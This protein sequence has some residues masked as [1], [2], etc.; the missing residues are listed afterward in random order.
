MF[1]RPRRMS[2]FSAEIRSHIEMETDRLQA[3]GMDA[4]ASRA[5][6]IRE[7]GNRAASEERFFESSPASVVEGLSRDLR[8]ASRVLRKSPAFTL[9]A[10]LSLALGIGANTAIFQLVD[11]VRL[12][13]LPVK[14][15]DQLVQ[16]RLTSMNKVRGS[17]NGLNTLTYPIWNEIRG[18]QQA[19]SEIFAWSTSAYDLA[20]AGEPRF[21]Q[22]MVVSGG[23]FS[24][25]GLEPKLGRLFQEADDT[26]GCGFP[27]VVIS[28]TFWQREYGGLPGAIGSKLTLNR[29]PVEIIGVTSPGFFGMVVGRSFDVAVPVCTQGAL[30]GT[31]LQSLGTTWWMTVMG[32]VKPG[33]NVARASAYFK[34]LSPSVFQVSLPANY[35][36]V[37]VVDYVALQLVADP[38][39]RGVS[40]LREEYSEPLYLLLAIAGVVLL[41]TCANLANLMLARASAREREIAVRLAI[42]ASRGRL[43]R[44]L[45]VETLLI[46]IAGASLGLVAARVLSRLLVSLL[47]TQGNMVFINLDR[48]WRVFAFAGA[49]AVLTAI[50]F[51]LAPA[52]RSTRTGSGDV[53]KLAGRGTTAS[54]EGF[55]LRRMLVVVQVAL[56]LVLVVGALLFAGTLNNLLSAETGFRPEGVL[57]A[58]VGFGAL[59][60]PKERIAGFRQDLLE[61]LRSIP[62]VAAAGDTDTVPLSGN[63]TS[64]AVW[65]EGQLQSQAHECMRSHIGPGYF[66]ALQIPLLAGR[67]IDLHDGDASPRVAV[68]NE[69][70]ARGLMGGA[71]PVGKRLW[72]EATPSEPAASYEIVGM[73]RNTKYG[74]LREK[75]PPIVYQAQSQDPLPT[76]ADSFVIRSPLPMDALTTAVRG[77][78]TDASPGIRYQFQVFKT[79]IRDTLLQERLMASLSS[80]FGILASLLAAIGLYGVMAYL[81]TRRRNE[82]GIRMALGAGR[83]EI[84]GMVLRESGILLGSGL[85]AGAVLSQFATASVA[86][87]LFGLKATDL[88]SL[89]GAAGLLAVVALAASYVPARRAANLD[90]NTA[91]REE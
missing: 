17:R 74:E 48:D 11:A 61:R 91:L 8:Y 2:D 39:G 68:V 15:P 20:T 84:V 18:R 10:V 81:V 16:V 24:A 73:V 88:R 59:H 31:D 72:V 85:V 14:N 53:L 45:M 57:I 83:R 66:D 65:M 5:Q 19:L 13:M 42:G 29:H 6:A 25:L 32:R 35:P 89:L 33:W 21:I 30:L 58:R 43:V 22:G 38:A 76:P 86:S 34:S 28:Y 51:G 80:A 78:L 54:R 4:S 3:Q 47:S 56:S 52:L 75:F 27:G 79:S 70:F 55:G 44:Q 50:L 90:P 37:S 82:I 67:S 7:F 26:P 40:N 49:L 41:I 36:P 23:F 71:N 69:A 60:L 87:L 46:S 12:R 9:V 64:N 62:G 77:A 63:F 1:R